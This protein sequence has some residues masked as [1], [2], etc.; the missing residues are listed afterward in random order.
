MKKTISFVL[1]LAMV[2]GL[3]SCGTK[4]EPVELVLNEQNSI[5][6]FM[7]FKLIKVQSG[8]NL[9]DSMGTSHYSA[10]DGNVYVDTVFDIKNTSAE[11]L[12]IEFYYSDDEVAPIVVAAENFDGTV[13]E[14]SMI[15]FESN[16]YTELDNYSGVAPQAKSRMHVAAIVPE[17]ETELTLNFE[18]N[19]VPYFYSYTVGTEVGEKV[20]IAIDQEIEV[21]DY[22]KYTFRGIEIT[23][24]VKPSNTDGSY[25]YY[26]VDDASNTY[27]VIKMDV[28]NLGESAVEAEDFL[29]VK[30]KYLDK[31]EYS[32]FVAVEDEDQ[33]GFSTWE[34][35]K[36]L[37]TRTVYTLIEVPDSVASES[38]NL[39]LYIAGQEYTYTHDV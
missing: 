4:V 24:D 8:K 33:E 29:N 9:Y 23:D 13:F 2:L 6:E 32:G 20:E 27:V 5:E 38:A 11:E 12:E 35:I 28:M 16:N 18:F 7:D 34:S 30:A 25:S 10:E 36:P 1:V 37:T 15:A 22:A 19:G 39:T 26:E 14:N 3:A 31:Y 21:E 17:G